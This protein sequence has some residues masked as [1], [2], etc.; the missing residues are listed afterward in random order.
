MKKRILA[1]LLTAVLLINNV[2][3]SVLAEQAPVAP[4]EISLEPGADSL[5]GAGAAVMPVDEP[6]IEPCPTCGVEGCTSEHLNWCDVCEKDDCGVDHTLCE[7]CGSNPCVCEVSIWDKIDDGEDVCL[8]G[9]LD[10]SAATIDFESEYNGTK[11]VS[12]GECPDYLILHAAFSDLESGEVLLYAADSFDSVFYE[13]VLS[14]YEHVRAEAFSAVVSAEGLYATIGGADQIYLYNAAGAD[15]AGQMNVAANTIAG[16]YV[17]SEF[18]YDYSDAD[19]WF[20]QLTPDSKWPATALD[21]L[22]IHSENVLSLSRTAT[23]QPEIGCGCCENCTGVEDC[24]CGCTDCDF[25]EEPEIPNDPYPELPSVYNPENKVAVYA[26]ELPTGTGLVVEDADVSEQLSD[27]GIPEENLVFAL[28]ISLT[29]GGS[30]YQPEG[31]LVRIAVSQRAGTLIGILHTHGGKTT[32][33]GTTKVLSDGTIEF[34]TDGFSEFAGFTVDFHYGGVDFSIDGMTS[35][36]LSELFEAMDIDEDAYDATSV[37]FSDPTLV[38]VTQEGRD[39]RLTSLKAFQTEESLVITFSDDHV[40]VIDVTDVIYYEG[41]HGTT[42]EVPYWNID[43]EGVLR[44]AIN[45]DN[46]PMTIYLHKESGASLGWSIKAGSSYVDTSGT[47]TLTVNIKNNIPIESNAVDIDL[48]VGGRVHLD[49]YRYI[50]I[51]YNNGG[52]NAANMPSNVVD[53]KITTST[54]NYTVS[55]NIPTVDGYTFS[56]WSGSNGQTYNRGATASLTSNTTLTA[57]WTAN[58]N[59]KYTVETYTQKLDGTYEKKTESKTGTTDATVSVTPSA[60]TG[61]I[62]N[63]SKSTVSGKI[64]GNGSLVLKVYYDRNSYTVTTNKGTGINSVSGGGTYKYGA[65]VS[66]GATVNEGYAWKNWTGYNT[67]TAQNYSFTMPAANVTYTA[68][69]TANTY[70]IQFN[71]NGATSGAMTNQSFT[72]GTAQNLTANAY[73]REYTVTYNVNGGNAIANATAKATFNG[74]EDHGEIVFN[75][76]TWKHTQFDA[77]FYAKNSPDV[78][79]AAG[80]GDGHYNKYG[81]LKHFIEWGKNEWNNGS[82]G[83]APTGDT[84]G[85]YPNSATVSNLSTTAGYV[86][87]LYANWTLGSVTLPTPTKTGHTFQGWYEDES[88]T[89]EAGKAGANYQPEKNITLYAKWTAN[90]YTVS[91]D[92]NYDGAVNDLGSIQVTYGSKYGTLHDLA[93]TRDNYKFDGWYTAESGGTK[94]T[95]DTVYNIADNSTLYAHW[96]ANEVTYVVKHYLQKLDGTYERDGDPEEKVGLAGAQVTP[97]VK[98]YTGFE[99]PKAQ[100]VT[101]S[102]DGT[103]VVN[104]YYDRENYTVKLSK[105]TG[106][107]SVTGADSYLYEES[108][109]VD[110]TLL[111]GY[112][113]VGWSGTNAPSEQEHSFAMPAGNR[114]WTATAKAKTYTVTLNPN[115]GT[116]SPTSKSVTYNTAYGILPTPTRNGYSFDGWFTEA[117]D[118]T[119]VEANTVYTTAGNSTIYA[120][121]TAIEYPIVYD[122]DGGTVAPANYTAYTIESA[123]F[124]LHNPVKTG[125]D[126]AGWTGTDLSDA[127]K[128]VTVENGSTGKREYTATWTPVLYNITYNLAGGTVATGNPATYTIETETFTLNNPTKAGYDFTGWTGTGLNEATETVSV[129]KGNTGHRSYTA[130]WKVSKFDLTIIT[131]N[132]VDDNQNYLFDVSGKAV[133]DTEVSLTVVLGAK[134]SQTIVGL[135]AGDYTVSDRQGW[136]WRYASTKQDVKYEQAET[137][138]RTFTYT[139]VMEG[140]IYWLNGYNYGI[141]PGKKTKG[142]GKR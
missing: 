64:A 125:Y 39:W 117:S 45:Y 38:E 14:I 36:L 55:N 100:T 95:A 70:A 59:T 114:E 7:S 16:E 141:Q 82:T 56:N 77:P 113:W 26:E 118:G 81:L 96:T 80:Y 9:F 13:D 42:Y 71:G 2:P 20:F 21:Y 136:S 89:V 76:T 84:P 124:T 15:E 83:R 126:F 54:N 4:A 111:P 103:T 34:F 98:T 61:F 32:Y 57:N 116:V 40:T 43:S 1:L 44:I 142:G 133:D 67:Q 129:D 94:V 5:E 52:K 78:V 74:W 11:S 137:H 3:V 121:W 122:L 30:D 91:F 62:Y 66:L 140:K 72:F 68:N 101:V 69:A 79:A 24:N 86:V 139:A 135:P 37:V 65:S 92:K 102:A 51:T 48:E 17:V 8:I 27:F 53:K 50:D 128:E 85:L 41:T 88:L 29:Q 75:G 58:T 10:K 73:K 93:D 119:K 90:P 18:S 47:R 87:P 60:P 99:S 134:D 123:S 107:A 131:N 23:V 105:G 115:G 130:M 49:V 106:I 22:W 31:A 12:A 127:T 33:I 97:A 6:V 120:Q 110:A 46:V 108:V 138:T 63:Q 104:Y 25:Y 19:N 35:I 109:T 28:D 132:I 112:E